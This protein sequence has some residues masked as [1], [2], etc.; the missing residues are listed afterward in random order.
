MFSVESVLMVFFGIGFLVFCGFLVEGIQW[1]A[2]EQFLISLC[3]A[4]AC[5]FAVYC[6]G[7]KLGLWTT[8][9]CSCDQAPVEEIVEVGEE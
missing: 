5:L 7:E 2:A 8:G 6:Y 9:R 4:C 1:G 3:L